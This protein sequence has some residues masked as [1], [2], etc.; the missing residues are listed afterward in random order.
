MKNLILLTLIL[1]A[2]VPAVAQIYPGGVDPRKSAEREKDEET[3]ADLFI[4]L[5]TSH[6]EIKGEYCFDL[7]I[8]LGANFDYFGIG[9]FFGSKLT[10][11]VPLQLS[12]NSEKSHLRL[13]Y[14][15][16]EIAGILP[17]FGFASLSAEAPIGVGTL[18]YSK[19]VDIG[20]AGDL[21]T[22]IIFI[23]EPAFFLNIKPVEEFEAGLGAAYGTTS[24]FEYYGIDQKD[25][26][27]AVWKIRLRYFL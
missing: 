13:T 7:G 10:K 23:S 15:G 9:A 5:N 22:K 18:N 6:Y 8:T 26:Q 4:S 27:G 20:I 25:L 12:E 14:G 24:K 2:V 1:F 17:V 11:N 16:A 21:D 19:S 3:F